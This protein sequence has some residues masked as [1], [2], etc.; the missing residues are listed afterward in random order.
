MNGVPATSEVSQWSCISHF[1]DGWDTRGLRECWTAWNELT[2]D[3]V[4]CRGRQRTLLADFRPTHLRPP[5]PDRGSSGTR[6]WL[7]RPRATGEPGAAAGEAEPL[8]GSFSHGVAGCVEGITAACSQPE[9]WHTKCKVL[10]L[11]FTEFESRDTNLP[12]LWPVRPLDGGAPGALE[13]VPTPR[14]SSVEVEEFEEI[15]GHGASLLEERSEAVLGRE[16]SWASQLAIGNRSGCD[17]WDAESTRQDFGPRPGCG[18]VN[19]DG[20]ED[21]YMSANRLDCPTDC[22]SISRK[23][24]RAIPLL[25]P[26]WTGSNQPRPQSSLILTT[27]AMTTLAIERRRVDPGQR[28]P[29][30]V[31]AAER[32]AAWTQWHRTGCGGL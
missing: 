20:L 23:L 22:S 15:E 6:G 18:D 26:A 16:P 7:Y 12:H 11:E 29:G 30:P 28:W 32:P 21:V 10:S 5:P 13:A 24:R 17:G 25:P 31:C 2:D 4:C 19:G 3:G 8:P 27:T 14:L 9:T 1:R